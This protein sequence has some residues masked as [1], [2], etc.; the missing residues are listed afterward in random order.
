MIGISSTKISSGRQERNG[1]TL[2]DEI[3]EI[4]GGGEEEE[5]N[6]VAFVNFG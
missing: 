1:R 6:E 2:G 5:E 3:K 4:R